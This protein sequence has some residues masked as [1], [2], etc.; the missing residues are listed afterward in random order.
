MFTFLAAAGTQASAWVTIVSLLVALFSGGGVA[1]FFSYRSNKKRLDNEKALSGVNA[2]LK[3]AESE[4]KKAQAAKTIEE[5]LSGALKTVLDLSKELQSRLDIS[6]KVIADFED[7]YNELRQEYLAVRIEL[8][9]LPQLKG[10]IIK[11]SEF[12]K[13]QTSAIELLVAQLKDMDVEPKVKYPLEKSPLW[14]LS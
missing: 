7:K 13:E 8:E 5:G 1:G 12:I 14:H 9:E 2:Q 3:V 10:M 11:Q 6:H 4:F